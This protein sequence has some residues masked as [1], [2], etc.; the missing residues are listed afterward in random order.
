MIGENVLPFKLEQ[1][2]EKLTPHAGLLMCHEFHVALGLPDLLDA[3]LPPPGSN[4][5]Y[6][7]SEVILPLVLM[8]QG[9]GDDLG[10]IAKIAED[11]AL[12][13]A[14]GFERVPDG[15][16]VGTW[17]R[18]LG[19]YAMPGLARVIDRMTEVRHEPLAQT[20]HVLDVDPTMIEAH[21]KDATRG[22]DGTVGYRPVLGFLADT[23]WLL[24]EVFRTGS[25][26]AQS[27][28]AEFIA[29][30]RGRMPKRHRIAEVR[31]DSEGYNHH[32]MDYC[33]DEGI[34]YTIGA[35]RDAA[36]EAL[37]KAIPDDAWEP[38]PVEK[39]ER[40]REVA[41]A[42][43]TLEAGNHS[44]RLVFVRDVTGQGELFDTGRI[45]RRA[46]A[47]NAPVELRSAIE[48]IE[49]YNQR[50]T[51]E[52]WIGE[53][54]NGFGTRGV[55]CGQQHANA[56]W[57]RIAALAYNLFLLQQAFGLPPELLRATVGTV[58][59]RLYQTAGRLVH[60]A[61][62]LILKVAA[63]AKTLAMLSDIRLVSRSFAFG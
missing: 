33:N 16:T 17:M 44:F 49:H 5:G 11:D 7:P 2:D 19:T 50:G 61:R 13:E 10:D 53:V 34:L 25:A 1:T 52:Q 9:G 45:R 58:R 18:R 57:F 41:E 6:D 48:V 3:H 55:P 29:C 14:A 59:W 54:K 27:Y 42:V 38:V 47:T 51:A 37:Y 24:H 22:H 35:D 36:V 23:R 26:S 20:D 63:D 46:V 12:C 15:T 4:R 39:G 31:A 28:M 40:P 30:C 56:A 62:Q 8:L 43:H 21:K 32:V 60:H